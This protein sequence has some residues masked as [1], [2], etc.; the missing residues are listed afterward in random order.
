MKYNKNGYISIEAMIVIAISFVLAIAALALNNE[1]TKEMTNEINDK[2]TATDSYMGN[3]IMDAYTSDYSGADL[4]DGWTNAGEG[5]QQGT[6]VPVY[7]MV[8]KIQIP[9]NEYGISVGQEIEIAL[10]VYPTNATQSKLSWK[11][12]S[13][14]DKTMITRDNSGHNG[15]VLGLKAGKTA[16]KVSATDGSGTSSTFYVTVAQPVTGLTLD[17]EN[18]TIELSYNGVTSSTVKA[19]VLPNTGDSI[20]TE[21]RVSWS[22]GNGGT[23]SE[24]FDMTPNYKTNILTISLTSTSLRDYCI[25]K[26][27]TIIAKTEDGGFQKQFRVVA[28]N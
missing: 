5:G 17:K 3:Q 2:V 9:Q 16:I 28:R 1:N 19:T 24:C 15:T 12:V 26:S 6:I 20:A 27:V 11:V 4:N 18:Q 21:K 10:N 23:N 8:D 7:N 14:K 22:F 25:N 13:G